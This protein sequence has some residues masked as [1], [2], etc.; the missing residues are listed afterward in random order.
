MRR[1][2]LTLLLPLALIIGCDG[3]GPS[4][5]LPI[6][7]DPSTD[8]SLLSV[9]DTWVAVS[10]VS[11]GEALEFPEFGYTARFGADGLVGGRTSANSYGGEYS[12]GTDGSFSASDL[13]TTLVGEGPEAT[14]LS[15]ALLREM[16]QAT[17][18]EVED[19]VLH[20]RAPDGDGIR[21]VRALEE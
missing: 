6:L 3:F 12:A 1:S 9:R 19:I 10:A 7:V 4:D 14:R 2:L 18:F 11:D 15:S 21:F 17:T 5:A 16:A 20:L 13:V 8:P